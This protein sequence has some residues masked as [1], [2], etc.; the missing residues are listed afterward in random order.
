MKLRNQTFLIS[1]DVSAKAHNIFAWIDW[2]IT[3]NR[4]LRFIE[5]E[6]T[7]RYTN[8]TPID[9]DTLVKYI[10]KMVA[11]V[12]AIIKENL[13]EKFGL[14]FDG[15]LDQTSTHYFGIHAAYSEDVTKSR[16]FS[17]FRLYF[18]KRIYQRKVMLHL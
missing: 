4:P 5:G 15:W 2:I 8:L 12:K 18:Q 16:S 6:L 3:D 11:S 13:P 1:A 10:D 7:R 17:L 14:V 9:S